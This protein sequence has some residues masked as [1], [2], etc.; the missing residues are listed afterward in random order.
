MNKIAALF[1][2]FERPDGAPGQSTSGHTWTI[3]GTTLPTIVN[4]ELT[5]LGPT[6]NYAFVD[7][8]QHPKRMWVD[9]RWEST[10][11]IILITSPRGNGLDHMTHV[12]FSN[13]QCAVQV[14]ETYGGVAGTF[15]NLAPFAYS[16]TLTPGAVYQIGIT[17]NG[18]CLLI[19]MPDGSTEEVCHPRIANVTGRYLCYQTR[20]TTF[21]QNAYCTTYGRRSIT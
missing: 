19:Q 17:Y 20:D 4:G 9:G 21:I 16:A 10:D 5:G 1:D 3:S 2:D 8:L 18:P 12:R 7:V 15:D 6:G 11:E 13:T 14:R